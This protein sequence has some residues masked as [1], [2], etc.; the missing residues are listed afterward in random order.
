M[1]RMKKKGGGRGEE[2]APHGAKKKI[3]VRLQRFSTYGSSRKSGPLQALLNGS[4]QGLGNNVSNP[5]LHNRYF[6]GSRDLKMGR[7][8][9]KS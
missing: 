3:Q 5:P 2:E 8:V 9:L 7:A 1:K 6:S 4:Q